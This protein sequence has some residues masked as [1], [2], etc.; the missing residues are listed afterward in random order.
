MK[1][2]PSRISTLTMKRLK[3]LYIWF[4]PPLQSQTWNSFYNGLF[5]IIN[6]INALPYQF[7][8]EE[9]AD[10]KVVYDKQCSVSLHPDL[11]P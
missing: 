9:I 8:Q 11:S 6:H 4:Y 1:I 2:I 10:L 3:E 5:F 7:T